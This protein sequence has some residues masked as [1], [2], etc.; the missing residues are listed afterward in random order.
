MYFWLA[1]SQAESLPLTACYWDTAIAQVL[2]IHSEIALVGEIELDVQSRGE[3]NYPLWSLGDDMSL[4]D[5]FCYFDRQ[6][7]EERRERMIKRVSAL[8]VSLVGEAWWHPGGF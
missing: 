4:C 8:L 6:E 2:R 3:G 1:V 7:E 5:S